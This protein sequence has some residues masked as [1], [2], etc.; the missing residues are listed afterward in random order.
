MPPPDLSTGRANVHALDQLARGCPRVSPRKGRLDDCPAFVCPSTTTSVE[1]SAQRHTRSSRG[2]P[3]WVTLPATVRRNLA[4]LLI[5]NQF[6]THTRSAAREDDG[7]GRW[8]SASFGTLH[9]ERLARAA[10]DRLRN[11]RCHRETLEGDVRRTFVPSV[12]AATTSNTQIGKT[13]RTRTTEP[14][15]GITSF[16]LQ[17]S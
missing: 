12:S 8:P 7:E 16:H 9:V 3:G 17:N 13:M 1:P 5:K 10:R 2:F 4:Q 11:A 14:R 6:R 15:H